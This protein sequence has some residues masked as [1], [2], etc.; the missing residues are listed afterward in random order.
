MR[1]A[2]VREHLLETAIEVFNRHGYHA[3]GVDLLIA[4]AR[5]AKTTLYRHFRTK[6]DLIVAA[7][8]RQDEQ[9]RDE[10]RAFGEKHA[11]DPE[12]RLLA[13]FDLLESWFRDPGFNGCPFVSAACEHSDPSHPV[14]QAAVLHKRLVLA[15]FE[16]LCHA[17]GLAAAKRVAATMNLLHEGA[18]AVAQV[19][20]SPEPA[21]TAKAVA[22]RMLEAE[23]RQPRSQPA[24]VSACSE[25]RA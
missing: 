16:E 2:A 13:T 18:T 9:G 15:Y 24:M 12:G 10:M 5:V 17:M 22:A 20:R 8:H 23:A 6:E 19:T 4:E 3:A 1:R 14:F 21:R 25:G 11:Q 7:L